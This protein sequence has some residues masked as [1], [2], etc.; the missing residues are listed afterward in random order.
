MFAKAIV[1]CILRDNTGPIESPVYHVDDEPVEPRAKKARTSEPELPDADMD[2]GDSNPW[3]QVLEQVRSDLPKSGI[4]TWTNPLHAVFRAVQA[5]MPEQQIGAIKAGKGL[6]RY[7]CA[8]TGWE[9]EF[10]LR[11]TV[12][13]CSLHQESRRSRYRRLDKTHQRQ[14]QSP[15]KTQSCY[16]LYICQSEAPDSRG[17]ASRAFPACTSH[18]RHGSSRPRQS[19]PWFWVTFVFQSLCASSDVDAYVS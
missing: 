17:R 4:K 13:P 5:Q 10:P 6:D 9:D 18:T 2:G 14:T 3:K 11:K 8:E 7:I 15:C 1:K 19:Q 12:V 16:G